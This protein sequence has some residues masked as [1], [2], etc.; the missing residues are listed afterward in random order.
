M[1]AI[2]FALIFST[3]GSI[4]LKRVFAKPLI[5][6]SPIIGADQTRC[7]LVMIS[8]AHPVIAKP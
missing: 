8:A 2:M 6:S 1:S 7:I 3:K 4:C 5:L